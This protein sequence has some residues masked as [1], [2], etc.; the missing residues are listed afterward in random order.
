[1]GSARN[2]GRARERLVPRRPRPVPSRRHALPPRGYYVR[3]LHPA[4]SL[5]PR[6]RGVLLVTGVS[7]LFALLFAGENIVRDLTFGPRPIPSPWLTLYVALCRW[8]L[9]G[10]L[11]A[12]VVWLTV[13]YPVARPALVP[14]L[15]L[16]ALAAVGLAVL[17][18]VLL[19]LCFRVAHV[20]PRQ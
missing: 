13:R 10:V 5:S 9:Y 1:T 12:A 16:H 2:V 4:R 14:R 15:L 19:V 20:Y 18:N 3:V 8:L 11:A 17:H 6:A 7:L